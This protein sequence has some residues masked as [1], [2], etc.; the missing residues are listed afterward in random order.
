MIDGVTLRHFGMVER[1]SLLKAR[2]DSYPEPRWT[3]TVRSEVLAGIGRPECDAVLAAEFLGVP[4]EVDD[5][6]EL[7]QVF[8]LR[9]RLGSDAIDDDPLRDLGEAESIFVADKLHGAF[10]TDDAI[11]YDFAHKNLGSNRVLDTI[12]LL[13]EAV[14]FRELTPSE[15]QQVANEIR[16]SGRH[17]RS[18]HP[19]TL[20]AEYFGLS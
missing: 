11:A 13:R 19:R 20:T 4:Y 1:M 3:E 10:V 2:V 17:L 16:N 12:D 6:D 18:G 15:A 5:P 8:R 14:A 7:L 9:A